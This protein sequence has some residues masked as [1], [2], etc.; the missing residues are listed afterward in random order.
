MIFC[1]RENTKLMAHILSNFPSSRPIRTPLKSA[2][3]LQ[4]ILSMKDTII[5][6]LILPKYMFYHEKDAQT[7]VTGWFSTKTS[8]IITMKSFLEIKNTNNSDFDVTKI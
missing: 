8:F 1:Q 2:I 7:V 4:S 6:V 5:L 3:M